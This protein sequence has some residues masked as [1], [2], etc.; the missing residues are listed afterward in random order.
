MRVI[1]IV[2]VQIVLV[3]SGKAL[4]VCTAVHGEGAGAAFRRGRVLCATH[5]LQCTGQHIMARPKV[6]QSPLSILHNASK[7]QL[8]L[9]NP[10]VLMGSMA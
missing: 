4:V 9:Q 3:E 10:F 6:K 1:V 8:R 5:D 2:V 7:P